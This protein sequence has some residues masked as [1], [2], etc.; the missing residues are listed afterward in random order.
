MDCEFCLAKVIA[1]FAGVFYAAPYVLQF[2]WLKKYDPAPYI[3]LLIQL[4]LSILIRIP[5]QWLKTIYKHLPERVIQILK[6]LWL[7]MWILEEIALYTLLTMS[8]MSKFQ[9]MGQMSNF[10]YG[11]TWYEMVML[12]LSLG[13]MNVS[14]NFRIL[15]KF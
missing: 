13:K 14:F 12:F 2:S 6:L 10:N 1:F 9:R 7:S 5:S 8:L 11:L 3:F 4:F 15:L